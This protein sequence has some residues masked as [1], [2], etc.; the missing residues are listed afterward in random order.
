MRVLDRCGRYSDH[1]DPKN[2]GGGDAVQLVDASYRDDATTHGWSWA[3]VRK[4]SAW[5]S[6]P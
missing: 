3:K 5:V 1:N 4:I 2:E 6:G